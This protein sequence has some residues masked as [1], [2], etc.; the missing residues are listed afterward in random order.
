MHACQQRSFE[1]EGEKDSATNIRPDL[2][3]DLETLKRRCE[4]AD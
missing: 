4:E 1:E 2:D 3:N